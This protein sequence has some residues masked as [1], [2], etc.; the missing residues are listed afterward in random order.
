MTTNQETMLKVQGMSCGSCVRHVDAA[1]REIEGVHDVDVKLAEG[2]VRVT[3]AS[4]SV[5]TMIEALREAGYESQAA[6]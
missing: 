3:H 1:L 2:E 5:S 4:A 6:G